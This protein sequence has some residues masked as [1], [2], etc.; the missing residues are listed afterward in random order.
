MIN[1]TPR[2][3]E[4]RKKIRIG[5][6]K[7]IKKKDMYK[8]NLI[9]KEKRYEWNYV[10]KISIRISFHFFFQNANWDFLLWLKIEILV[11][12]YYWLFRFHWIF[13]LLNFTLSWIC[14][15]RKNTVLEYFKVYWRK[16]YISERNWNKWQMQS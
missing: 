15:V 12:F 6:K 7:I 5:E 8:K 14:G 1:Q 13:F 4:K 9:K 11:F 3:K 2:R 10:L 16:I